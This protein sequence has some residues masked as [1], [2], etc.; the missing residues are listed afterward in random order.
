MK[1]ELDTI[2]YII[3]VDNPLYYIG[4]RGRRLMGPTQNTNA[5][6]SRSDD[7][8]RYMRLHDIDGNVIP[9]IE[10]PRKNV[11]LTRMEPLA[12]KEEETFELVTRK[13]P[14]RLRRDA[15]KIKKLR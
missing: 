4:T 7:A 6:F 14:Q 3:Q 15:F 8:D 5:I 2:G 13:R 9:V 12:V 11:V 10:K 1:I